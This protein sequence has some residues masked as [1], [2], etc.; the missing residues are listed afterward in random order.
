MLGGKSGG[1]R[2]SAL[3]MMSCSSVLLAVAVAMAAL[4]AGAAAARTSTARTSAAQPRL[5]P[6]TANSTPLAL[7]AAPSL[8]ADTEIAY[9]PGDGYTYVAWND[10]QGTGIDLCVLAP[11]AT[12][13]PGGG[14]VALT[15][16]SFLPG[17]E[18]PVIGGLTVLP[19]G[20][21]VVLGASAQGGSGTVAWASAA[22]GGSFL[23]GNNGIQNSGN[24]ISPVSLYYTPNNA[25]AL[26]GADVA[27]LDG[28]GDLSGGG[29]FS[30]SPVA[31]PETPSSISSPNADT[32]GHYARK[33]LEVNGDQI[34]AEAAAGGKEAVVTVA[35]TYAAND[36]ASGCS[37]NSVDSGYG[38]AIGTV[39]GTGSGSL[40]HAGLANYTT[41]ACS[42]EAPVLASGGG[43]GIGV[44]EEEGAGATLT[45]T[46]SNDDLTIDWRPFSLN[47]TGT[48][49]GFG[50]P[51]LLQDITS[52]N[53]DGAFGFDASDDSSNGV[54]ASW[55]DEQGLVLD[56]SA[57]SGVTWDGTS[58]QKALSGGAT[59]GNPVIAGV[60]GGLGQVAYQADIGSGNQIFVQLAD[61]EPP[62][63]TTISTHQT[64]G[65]S[66][67]AD[68]SVPDNVVGE[69]DQAT[70]A[71]TNAATATGTFTY[72][73]YKTASCTGT[74]A[75]TGTATVAGG[76]V[77]ASSGLPKLHAGTYYWKDS[78]SGDEFN[79]AST[80][81]CGAEKLVV[82][83]IAAP[84]SAPTSGTTVT[85]TITCAGP[86]TVTITIELPAG[87]SARASD[88]KRTIKL[89]GG[90]FT[91]KGKKGGKEHLKLRWSKY[92]S[93]LLKHDHDKLTTLLLMKG[94]AAKS[95]FTTET[96]LKLRK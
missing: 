64:A 9:A 71:G 34:A 40:N 54:Y 89:S 68:I 90:K 28:Y 96:A 22:G 25:A 91:L 80:S 84:S 18:A 41:L 56:Y 6:H 1:R 7:G 70:L 50:P 12:S 35:D 47:S 74:A 29:F 94:K 49:G 11:N 45:S 59:Q 42:A 33:S 36:S 88:S 79:Q 66:T 3:L 5:T 38:L 17:D 39:G 73:L 53:N 8:G 67:G 85:L 52:H 48:S 76:I 16:A 77:P 72:A 15:D 24:Y 95:R 86:C 4:P 26:S 92:A 2:I 75:H 93:K 83:P 20:E 55:V 58:P 13:C 37:G 57:N 27:V 78:Y 61:F 44:I 81:T 60:S 51:V 10:P 21:V 87:G 30:D 23:S 14:P 32:S 63:P 19:G 65:T 62:A 43:A 82:V 46:S 69:T 31:G